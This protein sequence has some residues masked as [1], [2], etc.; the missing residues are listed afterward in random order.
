MRASSAHRIG[1]DGKYDPHGE[2]DPDSNWDNKNVEPGRTQVLM[3]EKGPGVITH[4]WMTFLGPEPHPWA[5]D[6]SADHQEMLLRITYDGADRPGIEAPVGDFFANC[7]GRRAEVINL[8]V[9]RPGGDRQPVGQADQPA[10]LQH[11]LD[12]E[13]EPRA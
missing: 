10:L 11:R 4:I 9:V 1:P 6:G 5:K 3:D 12:Q 2:F 7:F 13:G 8:P